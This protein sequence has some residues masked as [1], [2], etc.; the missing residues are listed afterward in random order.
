MKA[1]QRQPRLM[2]AACAAPGHQS[3]G[4]RLRRVTVG[5]ILG[6]HRS[7]GS[8][9]L[10]KLFNERISKDKKTGNSYGSGIADKANLSSGIT[11]E[12]CGIRPSAPLSSTIKSG[13]FICS[14]TGHF[15]LLL[16]GRNVTGRNVTGRNVTGRNV[17]EM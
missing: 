11:S 5:P 7:F 4:G 12:S 9:P 14:K 2:A 15:Y 3:C 6:A 1:T 13:Q 17:T 16:T 10:C 8:P